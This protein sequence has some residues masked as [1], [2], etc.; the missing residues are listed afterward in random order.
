MGEA[1]RRAEAY[2]K[3]RAALFGAIGA[4]GDA[5][6][7]AET[8]IALFERFVLPLRYTGGCYL[9]TMF[10]HRYLA[11]ERGITTDPVVGFVNDGTDD[12]MVSHAWLE[13][14][15][16][17]ADITLHLTDPEMGLSGDLIVLDHVLRP[18]TVTYSYHRELNTAGKTA[19]AAVV[20]AG[21]F[22]AMLVQH[23]LTEHAM[24]QERM[25]KP[26]AMTAHQAAAPPGLRYADMRA[27]I[28]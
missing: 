22:G 21:G 7:V 15:G 9:T 24:M 28:G 17:R 2:A 16:R 25:A 1:K 4:D 8:A 13:H 5:R 14:R 26:E 10:L 19:N 11:E 18:G 6:I 3:A 27:A 20:A 23:K 12:I